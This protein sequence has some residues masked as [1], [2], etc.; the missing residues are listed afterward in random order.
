[1]A[2]L[3]AGSC[4][5][6]GVKHEGEAKGSFSQLNDFEIY[7]SSPAD[8]STENGVLVITDVIG[9]R[10]LNAQLIAD[11]FAANGYFVMMPDLFDNDAIPLNRPEGF[12]LMAWKDGAY[13]KDKKPHTPE[14]VDPIIEACIKEMRTKYGCKKIGAVGYCF[15]GKYVVRH[16]RPG[17]IDAGYT[18]HPS[19]VDSEELKAIKGPLAI[20]AAETD[21]I[22]PSEKRHESEEIL[23]DSGLP[24]QIN[25]YSGVAHGF[26]VR[27]DPAN[28][29]VQYA[30]ENAFLQAVQWFKEHL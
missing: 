21:A 10:F 14:V 25:L 20:A 22:F 19:F 16:L 2:S 30:K 26:A 18:A 28:R 5:Y 27:G 7:T 8:K 11:Q 15:G 24:Y 1:M 9:H 17:Q 12:D 13:H 6:Q 23:K 4:C 3:P 29:T